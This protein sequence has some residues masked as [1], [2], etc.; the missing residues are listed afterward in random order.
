[1]GWV[2]EVAILIGLLYYLGSGEAPL[3]DI[4]AY[5][6][7]AFAGLSLAVIAKLLWSY[8]YSTALCWTKSSITKDQRIYHSF[9]DAG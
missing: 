6:G 3:L 7:Y 9:F 5:G 1:M 8:S 4:V 2:V